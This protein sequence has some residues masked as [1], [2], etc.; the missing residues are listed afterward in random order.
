MNRLW[1][2][3]WLVLLASLTVNAALLYRTRSTPN[4]R[5]TS[6]TGE[7]EGGNAAAVTI[8]QSPVAP[9]PGS[10]TLSA[11]L[12]RLP[13]LHSEVSEIGQKLRYVLPLFKIFRMGAP[14][15]D[16]EAKFRPIVERLLSVDGGHPPNH[17]VDCRDVVCRLTIVREGNAQL[18]HWLALQHDSEFLRLTTRRAFQG[19]NP[20]EDA[21]TGA[22]LSEER[23][24]F[25]LR[26]SDAGNPGAVN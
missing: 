10:E 7:V 22:S 12:R 6:A 17:V 24:Y 23:T 18:N 3:G 4:R 14:N 19:P 11:C 13:L 25:Q 5:A 26:E 15:N 8:M 16:A 1:A 9:P 21:R 2:L 20:T